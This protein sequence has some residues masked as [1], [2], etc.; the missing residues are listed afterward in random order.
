MR[1]ALLTLKPHTILLAAL[2]L[3][4]APFAAAQSTPS[5]QE[6]MSRVEAKAAAEHKA[7]LLDFGASWC[8]NCHLFE[9]FLSD[10]TIHPII[11]KHFVTVTL[12]TGEHPGDTKHAN[13]PGGQ[14]FEDSVG[15]KGTGWPYIVM[16]DANGKPLADSLRPTASGKS[17]IGY[18][19]SPAE[20]D[21][22]MQ[23]LQKSAPSLSPQ[24]T[25]TIHAWLTVHGHN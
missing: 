8:G 18:P 10:P 6:I 25:A 5:A 19:D 2:L 15:G 9:R 13:T 23:M 20:V 11:D 1:R 12:I 24:D 14:V 22:F 4:T 3:A 7:I 16:L 21:W 17:N